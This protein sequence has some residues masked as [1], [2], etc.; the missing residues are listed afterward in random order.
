MYYRG[1][2]RRIVFMLPWCGMGVHFQAWGA[3]V[4]SHGGCRGARS[5]KCGVGDKCWVRVEQG[6]GPQVAVVRLPS[7]SLSLC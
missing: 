3:W 7:I 2:F 4:Q 1:A 5:A 6:R